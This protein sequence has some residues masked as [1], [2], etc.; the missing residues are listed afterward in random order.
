MITKDFCLLISNIYNKEWLEECIGNC[1]N[2]LT[3]QFSYY[4][5]KY[6]DKWSC[7]LLIYEYLNDLK[8]YDKNYIDNDKLKAYLNEVFDEYNN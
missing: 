1:T 7:K 5:R 4:K 6:P 8:G 2:I 3:L